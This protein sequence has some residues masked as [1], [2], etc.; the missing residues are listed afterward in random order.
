VIITLA[1]LKGGTGKTILSL[2]IAHAI[3]LS[4]KRVL[5][6]D[7][8]PQGSASNWAGARDEAAPFIIVGMARDNLHKELTALAKDFDHCVID[9]A[10]RVSALARSAILAADVVLCPLQPS[11]FDVWAVSETATLIQEAKQFKPD[12]KAGF[13][14]NRKI[15]NS[16][17]GQEVIAALA[18]YEFPVLKTTIAQRVAFA[19]AAAGYSIFETAPKSPGA[20]E[21]QALSKDIL[22]LAGVKKW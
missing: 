21:I 14:V 3:A 1:S 20:K 9:T 16:T 13:I 17:I 11:S 12:I 6:I 19:E 8:D 15:A 22:N 4:K 2:H 5:L 18:D 7:A 10:P